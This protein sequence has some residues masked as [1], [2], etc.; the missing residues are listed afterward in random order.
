MPSGLLTA[1]RTEHATSPRLIWYGP[2]NE[3][4]ELSGRVLENWAAKTA[5]LLVDELDAGPGTRVLLDLPP[6]WKSLVWALGAWSTGCTVVPGVDRS[7]TA[8]PSAGSTAGSTADGHGIDVVVT[9]RPD[10]AP[11]APAVQVAV[12]L[13]AMAMAWPGQLPAG[14]LDY[15]SEVRAHG[16][17][18]LGAAEPAAGDPALVDDDVVTF[19]DLVSAAEGTAGTV[20]VPATLPLGRLLRT[21]PGLW[22]AGNAVMLVHAEVELTD[23]L[24]QSERVTSRL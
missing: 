18:Y 3:R 17:V 19:A 2:G 6:H 21:V 12:A 20:L 14:T 5:N 15:A 4:V 24:L 23:R 16:D 1:L 9:D 8:K 7:G 10:Q 13:G 22:A 11:A